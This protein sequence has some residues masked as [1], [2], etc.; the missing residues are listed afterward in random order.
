MLYILTIAVLVALTSANVTPRV[1]FNIA[2]A[3]S[4]SALGIMF[5]RAESVVGF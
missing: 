3:D 5:S 4:G 2:S 1:P